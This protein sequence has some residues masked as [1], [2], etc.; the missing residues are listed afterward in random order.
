MT[1]MQNL[2]G[3]QVF[4]FDPTPMDFDILIVA[5][6]L[7]KKCRF[8]GHGKAFFSVAQHSVLV[9][10]CLENESPEIQMQ[11]L[12]HEL[13]EIYFPDIPRPIKKNPEFAALINPVLEKQMIA[14]CKYFGISYP[15]SPKV[16][17]AD[18]ACLEAEKED[19]M[20][21]CEVPWSVSSFRYP[22]KPIIPLLPG[23]AEVLFLKRFT[24]LGYLWKPHLF[25]K[26]A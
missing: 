23:A 16:W 10:Q 11:G 15:F 9:S 22:K 26:G 1:W 13:D 2:N 19:F 12:L 17:E 8:N 4:P 6:V 21:P 7:S 3:K 20:E 18:N 5:G 24:E 14:G 25:Q